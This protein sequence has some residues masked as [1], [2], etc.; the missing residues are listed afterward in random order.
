MHRRTRIAA[1]ALCLDAEQRVLLCRIAPHIKEGGWWTLPGGGVEFGEHP[2]AAALRELEEEAGLTGRLEGLVAV[3]S[4]RY[5]AD[6]TA[7]GVELHAIRIVYQVSV[8]GGTLRDELDGSSDTCGWFSRRDAERLRLVDLARFGL[9]LAFD[10]A[11]ERQRGSPR[12]R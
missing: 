8:T 2:E 1:Y 4:R 3:D 7:A 9:E 6:E 10:R 11:A 5:T 12:E